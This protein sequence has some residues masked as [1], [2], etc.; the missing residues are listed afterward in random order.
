VC[1][2]KWR[3]VTRGDFEVAH[4]EIRQV[5]SDRSVEV[6]RPRFDQAHRGRRDE[7][8]GVRADLEKRLLVN[9]QR[10]ARAG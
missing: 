6:E 1:V 5:L 7:G 4:R 8:F 2:I 9:R 3:I 10:I